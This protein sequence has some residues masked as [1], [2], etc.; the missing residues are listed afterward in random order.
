MIPH[1]LA[2][3]IGLSACSQSGHCAWRYGSCQRAYPCQDLWHRNLQCLSPNAGFPGMRLPGR[4]RRLWR[5]CAGSDQHGLCRHTFRRPV[6]ARRLVDVRSASEVPDRRRRRQAKARRDRRPPQQVRRAP[7]RSP[8]RPGR[9]Q[10]SCLRR[11][12]RVP[13]PRRARP[14]S[15]P[16][17]PTSSSKAPSPR[18]RPA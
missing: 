1:K 16:C 4:G 2:K 9:I 15:S 8:D 13:C 10:R 7:P 14:A 18:Q 5:R 12:A 3:R 6:G 17:S 11:L